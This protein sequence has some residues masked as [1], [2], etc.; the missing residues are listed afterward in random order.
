MRVNINCQFQ[1]CQV[2][3]HCLRGSIYCF[4]CSVYVIGLYPG[5][6]DHLL[7]GVPY[8]LNS[9]IVCIIVNQDSVSLCV[10]GVLWTANSVI[11]PLQ[12]SYCGAASHC[13]ELYT[14]CTYLA[15]RV[16]TISG[17]LMFCF[18]VEY[19][20]TEVYLSYVLT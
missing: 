4:D 11:G 7:H 14:L 3:R 13:T 1:C 8:A 6:L 12:L 10:Y 16:C 20:M 2:P 18:V 17:V 15:V 9:I 19:Q 5:M